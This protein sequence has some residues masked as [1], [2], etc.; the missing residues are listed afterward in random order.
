MV[1]PGLNYLWCHNSGWEQKRTTLPPRSDSLRRA[2]A[3]D[4]AP[5][6]SPIG[7]FSATWR[8]NFFIFIFGSFFYTTCNLLLC[9]FFCFLLICL[10]PFH[11][12]VQPSVAARLLAQQ[13]VVLGSRNLKIKRKK[14]QKKKR[15]KNGKLFKMDDGRGK[16][17]MPRTIFFCGCC[18]HVSPPITNVTFQLH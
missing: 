2:V 7:H 8:R 9:F 10:H 14:E 3:P 18:V 11:L 12:F 13:G 17:E 6:S 4:L 15:K 16:R 1:A 5:P